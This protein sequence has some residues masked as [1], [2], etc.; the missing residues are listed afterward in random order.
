MRAPGIVY[1][2]QALGRAVK[3]PGPFWERGS[4]IG[5]GPETGGFREKRCA[6][7]GVLGPGTGWG[8][9]GKGAE[10]LRGREVL[11]QPGGCETVT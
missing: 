11:R 6:A 1:R 4:P 5:M 7:R 8:L 10:V 3:L 2:G 9:R